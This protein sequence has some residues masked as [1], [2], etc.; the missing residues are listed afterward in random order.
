[1]KRIVSTTLASPTF[2]RLMEP[3][4]EAER[5]SRPTPRMWREVTARVWERRVRGL[6]PS[7]KKGEVIR[8]RNAR[9]SRLDARG[10]R[11]SEATYRK[12]RRGPLHSR[13]TDLVK[14]RFDQQ[15]RRV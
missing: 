12:R 3:S 2:Q 14:L 8:A 1:M 5:T 9:K 7:W 13:E 4:R 15:L 10:L 11:K 6:V